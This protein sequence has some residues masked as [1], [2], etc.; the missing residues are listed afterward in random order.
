MSTVEPT[1]SLQQAAHRK[2]NKRERERERERGRETEREGEKKQ[3]KE[4]RGERVSWIRSPLSWQGG[5]G[6]H[7]MGLRAQLLQSSAS[8]VNSSE[9]AAFEFP[10]ATSS[11]PEAAVFRGL[12]LRYPIHTHTPIDTKLCKDWHI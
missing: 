2:N 10:D 3:K 1:R 4:T 8:R 11:Q 7:G 5:N 12:Q 6:N 9:A